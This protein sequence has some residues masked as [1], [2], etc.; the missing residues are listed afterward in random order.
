MKPVRSIGKLQFFLILNMKTLN[1][2]AV[3]ITQSRLRHHCGAI[4]SGANL[5][6]RLKK[7]D[8]YI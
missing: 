4:G 1:A 7:L 3:I 6:V 8:E 2:K 5:S